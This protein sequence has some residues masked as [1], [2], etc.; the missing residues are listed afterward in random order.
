MSKK[1]PA[2]KSDEE[3]EAW[4]QSANLGE[5][6]LSEMKKVRFELAPKDASIS[7]RLPAALL[8]TLKAQAAKAKMPTQRLIRMLLEAQLA[9][10][11][12]GTKKK[13]P[14]KTARPTAR[15]GKRAA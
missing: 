14:P 2:L 13:R 11:A 9:E 15:S 10:G 5:Y 8:A 6:D 4:L 3:A 12:T 7:L 1:F